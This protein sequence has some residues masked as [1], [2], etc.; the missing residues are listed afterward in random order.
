VT[1]FGHYGEKSKCLVLHI[2]VA[3]KDM[4]TVHPITRY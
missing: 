3:V 2:I 1:E 4:N